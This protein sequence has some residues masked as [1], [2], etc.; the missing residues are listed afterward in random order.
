[1]YC[2]IA[3]SAVPVLDRTDMCS[4]FAFAAERTLE[5]VYYTVWRCALRIFVV[6]KRSNICCKQSSVCRRRYFFREY[7]SDVH[8]LSAGTCVAMCLQKEVEVQFCA[9]GILVL[10]LRVHLCLHCN[11][12]YMQVTLSTW[13]RATRHDKNTIWKTVVI[14]RAAEALLWEVGRGRENICAVSEAQR[15]KYCWLCC[16]YPYDKDHAQGIAALLVIWEVKNLVVPYRENMRI[17]NIRRNWTFGVLTRV[18]M[19]LFKEGDSLEIAEWRLSVAPTRERC[20]VRWWKSEIACKA[21][22]TG[23]ELSVYGDVGLEAESKAAKYGEKIS[24]DV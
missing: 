13:V 14:G 3:I 12:S 11:N 8:W 2:V 9:A 18:S 16:F 17:T 21:Y 22:I 6:Y 5:P 24:C 10:S 4:V 20:N 19:W 1:M 7:C 15:R 23:N